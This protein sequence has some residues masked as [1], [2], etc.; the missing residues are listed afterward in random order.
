MLLVSI[1]PLMFIGIQGYG[2]ARKAMVERTQQHLVS[3]IR[4]R[5]SL[6]DS[7]LEERKSDI[8]LLATLPIV[9]QLTE[10]LNEHRDVKTKR[11][12]MGL[13]EA[14]QT[15][16]PAYEDL[17][18]YNADFQAL[19]GV[20]FVEGSHGGHDFLHAPPKKGSTDSTHIFFEESELHQDGGNGQEHAITTFKRVGESDGQL[21][22]E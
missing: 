14:V 2:Y 19:V 13:L 9:P 3:V 8:G 4:A 11:Q 7:W 22:V 1:A 21:A 17:H 16:N 18:I 12:L 15:S 20:T 10:M 5:Q 6:F